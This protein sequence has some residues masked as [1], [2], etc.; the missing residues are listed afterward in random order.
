MAS[1]LYC[2]RNRFWRDCR[3]ARRRATSSDSL[4]ARPDSRGYG[5]RRVLCQVYG[6]VRRGWRRSRRGISNISRSRELSS[7]VLMSP[8]P[9][10]RRCPHN[11]LR[12]TS[13]RHSAERTHW[14]E[15][16]ERLSTMSVRFDISPAWN[17][18][19]PSRPAPEI[20][21]AHYR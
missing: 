8:E 12:R 5:P 6:L 9:A 16:A 18:P 1:L 21:T 14:V 19:V 7:G 15:A 20:Q 17:P 13:R 3:H 10:H 11:T 2:G 4:A